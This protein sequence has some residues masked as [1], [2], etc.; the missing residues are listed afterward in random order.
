MAQPRC[1]AGAHLADESFLPAKL[2]SV[3]PCPARS[4]YIE[5]RFATDKGDWNWCLP[6]P[7]ERLLRPP[8]T[9]AITGGPYG[10]QAHRVECGRLGPAL[11]SSEALPMIT[12]GATVYVAE[13]LVRRSR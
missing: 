9:L 7:S 1:P 11:S 5:L 13:W 10:A 4:D 3:R 12:N 6:K 8:Y 2:E